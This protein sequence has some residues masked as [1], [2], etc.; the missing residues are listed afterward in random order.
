MTEIEKLLIRR[1]LIDARTIAT[2]SEIKS[3]EG[4]AFIENFRFC[5]ASAICDAISSLN[6]PKELL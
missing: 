5:H 3:D 1:W 6:I 4:V 2:P